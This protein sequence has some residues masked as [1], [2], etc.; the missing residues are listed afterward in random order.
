MTRR[1]LI[2]LAGCAALTGVAWAWLRPPPMKLAVTGPAEAFGFV[3]PAVAARTGAGGTLME[4][5][6]RFTPENG[7]KELQTRLAAAERAAERVD[8][9][10]APGRKSAAS[11]GPRE[12]TEQ[13]SL[14]LPSEAVLQ[15]RNI[16]DCFLLM[17]FEPAS[18]LLEAPARRRWMGSLLAEAVRE[19]RT[20]TVALGETSTPARTVATVALDYGDGAKA[21]H[22]LRRLTSE[23]PG[24][25]PLGFTAA[26]GAAATS[27]VSG[28]VVIRLE[29]DARFVKAALGR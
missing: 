9:A 26:P 11:G 17:R 19:A 14:T 22:F 5:L 23:Q 16:E 4:A 12:L 20:A 8:F 27:R 2:W 1:A 24:E 18:G 29:A 15:G 25:T 7:R 28:L 21:E 3:E 10:F 13:A 6:V